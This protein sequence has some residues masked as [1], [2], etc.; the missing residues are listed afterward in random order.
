MIKG[1]ILLQIA[2][3]SAV[4]E[5][6]TLERFYGDAL[7]ILT[8]GFETCIYANI[9]STK[10]KFYFVIIRFRSGFSDKKVRA[11]AIINL[12]IIEVLHI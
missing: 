2:D 4:L 7:T 8:C 10:Y 5:A 9:I 12:I 6:V 11:I 1:E 3:L